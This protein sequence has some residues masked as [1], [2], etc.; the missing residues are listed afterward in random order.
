MSSEVFLLTMKARGVLLISQRGLGELLGA[1]RRTVQRW[2]SGRGGPS[3]GQLAHL[4]AAVHPR[5]A[6]LAAKIAAAAGTSL[7][8]LGLVRPAPSVAP[9]P[10]VKALAV[11]PPSPPAH[12][13]DAV[14]CAAAEALNAPPP[15]VR[16]V[17]LAA[18]RR[19]REVGLRVE[20][21]ERALSE[22]IEKR[23]PKARGGRR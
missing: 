4:A 7:E 16:P 21:V 6:S 9:P 11:P 5:D 19:A 14:V 12:L 15:A 20:D 22:A 3:A 17:L 13:T 1:S 2:D 8:Q 23:R 10:V 18:F